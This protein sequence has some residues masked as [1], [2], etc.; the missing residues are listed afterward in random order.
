MTPALAPSESAQPPLTKIKRAP[1]SPI[2]FGYC[3]TN[4]T[5]LSSKAYSNSALRAPTKTVAPKPSRLHELQSRLGTTCMSQAKLSYQ[6]AL[7]HAAPT[8]GSSILTASAKSLG[9]CFQ[10][11]S[12]S[13]PLHGAPAQRGV[14][15]HTQVCDTRQ[16]PPGACSQERLAARLYCEHFL[17]C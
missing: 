15:S 12:N 13:D 3:K 5:G 8:R 14:T 7:L 17:G 11:S 10:S 16:T 4:P 6:P 2:C 1:S 9:E